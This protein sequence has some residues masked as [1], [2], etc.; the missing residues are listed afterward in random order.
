MMARILRRVAR[1]ESGITIVLVLVMVLI[2]LAVVTAG[3][4]AALSTNGSASRDARVRRAQDAADAGI[5]AQL[6]DAQEADLGNSTYN[7]NGGPLSLGTLLDCTVPKITLGVITG[8]ANVAADTA[9]VCPQAES[10]STATSLSQPVGDHAYYSSEIIT[11]QQQLFGSAEDE[12]T[13]KIVSIGSETSKSKTVHSREEAILAPIAPLQAIEGMGSGSGSVAV[14]GLSLGTT[15]IL[16][17]KISVLNNVAAAVNG[18]ILA[19]GTISLPLGVVG[20][21]LSLTGDSILSTIAGQ[22]ITGGAISTAQEDSGVG[23]QIPV[24]SPVTVADSKSDCPTT[25][26]PTG[27]S[28]TT[29]AFSQTTNVNTTFQP[30][31]YVF[32]GFNATA[33]TLSTTGTGAVRIFIRSP[34]SP[35]CT[36]DSSSPQLGEFNDPIG[37]NNTITGPINGLN[38]SGLQIYNAGSGSVTVGG[39]VTASCS[40][41]T[42]LLGISVCLSVSVPIESM[43]VYAP[44]ST[45]S[46]STAGCIAN[47][48][49]LG[50][51]L[52]SACNAGIFEGAVIGNN[53]TVSATAITQDLDIGNFPL[54]AGVN[55]FRVTQ[56]IQCDNSV[57][58]L[59]GYSS[60]SATADLNGC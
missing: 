44:S 42:S 20:T 10:G 59:G 29:R 24:R 26:C 31:D 38:P 37:F 46:V 57:T 51:P 48:A 50:T 27:Y 17:L 15:S 22:T 23:S 52:V 1:D 35:D 18:D 36:G 25:G 19:R 30:G 41:G 7:L 28:S 6:Y 2:G 49:I 60:N 39:S 3:L 45:V 14:N 54:Y 33:G 11:G 55:A 5:Q 12:L 58:S 16:G 4:G 9:G 21:N 34:S 8:I 43:I 47:V 53:V 32:C 56:Y 13:P 40:V